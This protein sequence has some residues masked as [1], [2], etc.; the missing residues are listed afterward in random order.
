MRVCGFCVFVIVFF[1]L[2]IGMQQ[3]NLHECYTQSVSFAWEDI[4]TVY[5]LTKEECGLFY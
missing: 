2:S 3:R 5:H 4:H 1:V